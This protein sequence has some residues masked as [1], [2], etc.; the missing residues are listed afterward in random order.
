MANDSVKIWTN[1]FKKSETHPDFT[2]SNVM[3]NGVEC[4]VS[5]WQNTGKNGKPYLSLIAKPPYK[6][7]DHNTDTAPDTHEGQGEDDLPF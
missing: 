6:Q 5:V 2:A 7:A 3:I 4:D 1:N